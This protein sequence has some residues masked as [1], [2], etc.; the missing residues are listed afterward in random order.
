MRHA[1]LL[2][3]AMMGEPSVMVVAMMFSFPSVATGKG[4]RMD[5]APT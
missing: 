3:A 2:A 4:G 1:G 5:T